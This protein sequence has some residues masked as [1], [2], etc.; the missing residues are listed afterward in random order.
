MEDFVL[1]KHMINTY[2]SRRADDLAKL[3]Q[4]LNSGSVAEF[5]RIGHQLL[6]NARNYGFPDLEVLARKMESLSAENLKTEGPQIYSDF[7][8]WIAAAKLNFS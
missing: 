2:V 6:G 4:S 8:K 7:S 1:P 3:D 5:N